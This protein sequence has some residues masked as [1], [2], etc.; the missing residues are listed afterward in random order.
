M[1]P[2]VQAAGS[3]CTGLAADGQ[4]PGVPMQPGIPD[5]MLCARQ[6]NVVE[7]LSNDGQEFVSL[8]RCVFRRLGEK[9]VGDAIKAEL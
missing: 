5:E 4:N 9:H 1:S 7:V 6:L 8:N 2:L 3:L